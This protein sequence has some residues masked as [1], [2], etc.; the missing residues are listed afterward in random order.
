M[1]PQELP[2]SRKRQSCPV[3]TGY[4]V[5]AW[6]VNSTSLS[7]CF[8][9]VWPWIVFVCL[10]VC[11]GVFTRVNNWCGFQCGISM[12][13]FPEQPSACWGHSRLLKMNWQT[14]KTSCLHLLLMLF[15]VSKW[16]NILTTASKCCCHYSMNV[17]QWGNP[18]GNVHWAWIKPLFCATAE[19]CFCS[20]V[21]PVA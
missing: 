17:L 3:M 11:G 19:V 2:C 6:G 20:S 7:A 9:D 21:S 10:C 4:L 16:H 18:N 8:D 15:N 12:L 1:C 5:L 14:V 13:P